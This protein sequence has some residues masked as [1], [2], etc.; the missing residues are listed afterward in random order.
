MQKS[1]ESYYKTIEALKLCG[2][3]TAAG[4]LEDGSR[5]KGFWSGNL[6]N[7]SF[8]VRFEITNK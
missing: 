1:Q 7:L 2:Q 8:S 4:I 5:E 6:L 3:K